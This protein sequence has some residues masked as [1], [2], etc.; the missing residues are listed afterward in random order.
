MLMVVMT[1]GV[2][3]IVSV[4]VSVDGGHDFRS[5]H[6]CECHVRRLVEGRKGKEFS[7]V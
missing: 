6:D 5:C 2:V 4:S 7:P 3:M 1:L